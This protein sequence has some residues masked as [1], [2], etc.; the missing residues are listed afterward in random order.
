M[1]LFLNVPS[2]PYAERGERVD[3]DGDLY[4]DTLSGAQATG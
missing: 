4:D 3:G 2:I 1:T